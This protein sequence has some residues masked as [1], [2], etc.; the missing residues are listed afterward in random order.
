[1]A[2]VPSLSDE[3]RA[4]LEH[5]RAEKA[6]RM[7]AERA[8]KERAELEFLKKERERNLREASAIAHEAELRERGRRLM[9][10]DDVDLGM[11][12]GQKL[13][14]GTVLLLAILFLVARFLGA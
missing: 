13:V 8:A 9:E 1:M 7:E 2:D 12:L 11:P 14:L 10:P 6:A 5:L 4:E 3:E